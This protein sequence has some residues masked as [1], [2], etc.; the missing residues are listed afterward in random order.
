MPSG[1][2]TWAVG[3]VDTTKVN[4]DGIPSVGIQIAVDRTLVTPDGWARIAP[5]KVR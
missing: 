5:V 1:K 3:I 4:G 2:Y